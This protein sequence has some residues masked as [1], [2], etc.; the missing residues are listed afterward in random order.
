M[1][2]EKEACINAKITLQNFC[3]TRPPETTQVTMT[4]TSTNGRN[5]LEA[6]GFARKG[7]SLIEMLVVIAVIAIMASLLLS[8]LS[9]AKEHTRSTVCRN[10]MKQVALGFLMYA[11]DNNETLPW[12][13][14][15]PGRANGSA[16]YAADWCAGGQD[17]INPSLSSTWKVPGFG[18]DADAGSI[19]PYVTSQARQEYSPT[20]KRSYGVYRCPSAGDLGDAMRVNF[21]ANALMDPGQPFGA[22]KVPARGLM[23]TAV[24]DPARKVL[25]VNETA[26]AMKN[27]S[28]LPGD[29][30]FQKPFLNHVGR[31]NLA[32]MDGH[33]E[34]VPLKTFLRMQGTDA[35]IYFNA[36]K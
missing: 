33:M 28:F 13:G 12:P 35:D 9:Q 30:N 36:G 1:V 34:S 16:D 23:T 8:A 11:D 3:N 21:S 19:F 27:C 22:N 10:N 15:K 2:E 25:L 18:F 24:S 4:L 5:P 6:P 14:G 31:C 29:A 17:T 32:F 26:A 7:F 20:A